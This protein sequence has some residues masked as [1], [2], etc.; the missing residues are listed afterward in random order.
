MHLKEFQ[1]RVLPVKNKIYRFALRMLT[2]EQ[3]A[4]DVV[5][6]VLLKIW[7]KREEMHLYQNMEAWCMTITKNMCLDK[8]RMN[9][10]RTIQPL[11]AHFE[12][13]DQS[14]GPQSITETNDMMKRIMQIINSL[15]EKQKMVVQLR[16]I[17]GYTYQEISEML[18]MDM[19][20][21]KVNLFRARKTLKEKLINSE[22]YGL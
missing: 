22:A 7:N 19:N 18:E 20:Q 5:Q 8:F 13:S 12:I 2:D 16:D 11:D 15:P 9:N 3:D 4:K 1:N 10:R 14:G 6:E 17:E 21:V